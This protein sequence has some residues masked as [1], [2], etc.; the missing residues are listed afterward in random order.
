ML[1]I[2]INQ[3]GG[4]QVSTSVSV[5]DPS[6]SVGLNVTNVATNASPSMSSN[7]EGGSQVDTR[8]TGVVLNAF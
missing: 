2:P 1:P 5:V 3:E 8:G 6:T 4:T 7:E